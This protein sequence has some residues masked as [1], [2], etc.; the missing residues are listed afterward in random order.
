[1]PNVRPCHRHCSCRHRRCSGSDSSWQLR[2]SR[3][4]PERH[5]PRG[6]QSRSYALLISR[7]PTAESVVRS[8]GIPDTTADVVMNGL[9][10]VARAATVPI[11]PLLRRWET[12]VGLVG[13][14]CPEITLVG[15]AASVLWLGQA[16]GRGSRW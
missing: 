9:A 8:A 4:R 13:R 11:A 3:G 14:E 7:A 6:S 1:M 15:N 2:R 16:R 5:S 12:R 10:V